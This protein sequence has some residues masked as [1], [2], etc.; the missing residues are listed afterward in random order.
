MENDFNF[1]D[2]SSNSWSVNWGRSLGVIGDFVYINYSTDGT[3]IEAT[4]NEFAQFLH[5]SSAV[6]NVE[7]LFNYMSSFSEAAKKALC[8]GEVGGSFIFRCL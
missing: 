5:V 1:F 6:A 7:K 4:V 3:N 8:K 2:S